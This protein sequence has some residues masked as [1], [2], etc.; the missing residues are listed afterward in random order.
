MP[1]IPIP[2]NSKPLGDVPNAVLDRERRPT[3][4]NR[5]VLSAIGALGSVKQPLADGRALAAPYEALGAVGRALAEG[6][7]VLGALAIKRKEAEEYNQVTEKDGVMQIA[8]EKFEALKKSGL[9]PS[10]WNAKWEEISGATLN[11]ITSDDKLHPRARDKIKLR[12]DLWKR[13]RAASIN[14]DGAMAEFET[15][16]GGV[17]GWA[18]LAV[19]NQKKEDLEQ[20]LAIGVGAGWMPDYEAEGF[21]MDFEAEGE[22]QA[23]KV[24]ADALDAKQ[25]GLINITVAD[26][27]GLALSVLDGMKDLE[28][29]DAERLRANIKQVANQRSA[30]A[31]EAIVNDIASGQIKTAARVD[32]K[33]LGNKH[34]SPK[35]VEQV[36]GY[37]ETRNEV[38]EKRERERMV[39][40]IPNSVRAAVELRHRIADYDP[41]QDP[42]RTKYAMMALEIDARADASMTAELRG[43]LG[44]KYGR[45]M[46]K[47]VRPEIQRNVSKTLSRM[48]D[49]KTGA[50][51]WQVAVPVTMKNSDGSV[52]MSGGK[53]VVVKDFNG[54]VQTDWKEDPAAQQRAIDAQTLVEQHMSEWF[55]GNP[56]KANDPAAVQREMNRA[57]PDGLRG[58][59]FMKMQGSK[60]PQA[61]AVGAV[62]SYGYASDET[63]DSYSAAGIGAFTTEADAKGDRSAPTR[64]R[65]GDVAVSPDVRSAFEAANVKPR[66]A[67]MV[68]LANGEVRRVRWMDVTASDADIAAGKIKR[69]SKPLRGRFDFY[70]A[71]GKHSLDG[72]KVV[73]WW[74]PEDMASR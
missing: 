66:D 70:S 5:G 64:L 10:E 42:D 48:F 33:L 52:K 8:S 71:G 59:V 18:R 14:S 2:T 15:A 60:A 24:K 13:T 9:P 3:V 62:T 38:E 4:D 55:R 27:E 35:L 44:Q 61:A 73:K 63:P 69:V 11:E 17:R 57:L 34:V 74:K 47:D 19:K 20:Q 25:N 28:P 23:T 37:L 32:E 72:M 16:K 36:K 12:G 45:P 58:A 39:D 41:A 1:I 50:I 22:R 51:P 43:E 67:V 26:G 68:Q 40:G 54:N 56:D 21:R 30:E 65:D 29:V 7:G 6:G 46:P 49:P 53:P 31:A